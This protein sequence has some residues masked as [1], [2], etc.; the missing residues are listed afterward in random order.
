MMKRIFLLFFIAAGLII[1]QE[2]SFVMSKFS[3]GIGINPGWTVPEY[4]ELNKTLADFGM[5]QLAKEGFFTYGFNF[6]GYLNFLPDLRIGVQ[7]TTESSSSDGKAGNIDTESE[8]NLSTWGVSFEYTFHPM[9]KL[10]LSAGAVIGSGQT[11][12]NLYR[13]TGAVKLNEIFSSPNKSITLTNEYYHIT[14][15]I[16]FDYQFSTFFAARVGAG[17]QIPVYSRWEADNGIELKE[18]PSGINSKA[19]FIQ[20]GIYIGIF[21]Y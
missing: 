7:T 2:E 18:M 5:P 3:L 10:G 1:G 20:T 19:L 17:Y 6:Y 8:Y 15:I 13:N 16:N 14:P 12:I 4:T 21:S 11:D 9:R